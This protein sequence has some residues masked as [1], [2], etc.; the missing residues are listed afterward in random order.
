MKIKKFNEV[1]NPMYTHF[2]KFNESIDAKELLNISEEH[3]AYLLDYGF[4]IE[5]KKDI[6]FTDYSKV[7]TKTN[8][9]NH[10][11]YVN[12]SIGMYES[13]ISIRKPISQGLSIFKYN[14]IKDKFINFLIALNDSYKVEFIKFKGHNGIYTIEQILKERFNFKGDIHLI[15]IY[16]NSY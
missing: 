2:I 8:G 3:L 6:N 12:K 9:K 15:N 5:V 16:V 4:E 10:Y 13:L 7:L 14:E 1:F 11:S